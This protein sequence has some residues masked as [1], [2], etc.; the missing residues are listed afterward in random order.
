MKCGC[1]RCRTVCRVG[2]SVGAGKSQYPRPFSALR[3]NE[4]RQCLPEAKWN[5]VSHAFALYSRLYARRF[6]I[7]R[8][9]ALPIA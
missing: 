8:A 5:R 9:A 7:W 1:M 3:S 2:T 4:G 6:F